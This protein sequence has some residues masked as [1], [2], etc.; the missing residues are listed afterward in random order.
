MRWT[1]KI[2]S[3][4]MYNGVISLKSWWRMYY[5][6]ERAIE[7]YQI[8]TSTTAEKICVQPEGDC[9]IH[10]K[11]SEGSMERNQQTKLPRIRDHFCLQRM[12]LSWAPEHGHPFPVAQ[13]MFHWLL[14]QHYSDGSWCWVHQQLQNQPIYHNRVW[15]SNRRG[16]SHTKTCLIRRKMQRLQT[17]LDEWKDAMTSVLSSQKYDLM[18]SSLC[19]D[20]STYL[21]EETVRPRKWI[22]PNLHHTFWRKV[23][24]PS[25][26]DKIWFQI[27]VWVPNQQ[28]KKGGQ[29]TRLQLQ[30][31]V[32]LF[33]VVLSRL[34]LWLDLQKVFARNQILK[35]LMNWCDR[36]IFSL[37]HLPALP[38]FGKALCG[39]TH[40]QRL[41]S[42]KSCLQNLKH[43]TPRIS[44]AQTIRRRYPYY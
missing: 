21:V 42:W 38:L 32:N 8:N 19:K 31:P 5:I 20:A 44:K 30:P 16:K 25:P 7:K 2:F 37:A 27:R 43:A 18:E 41:P 28:L 13:D 40:L 12:N 29:T 39:Q 33:E 15:F 11:R 36:L 34:I 6:Y 17:M 35:K 9:L 4:N 24:S 10:A 26:A 14:H 23:T 1:Y 3:S 22:F